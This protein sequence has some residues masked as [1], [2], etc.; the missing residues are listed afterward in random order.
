LA[1]SINAAFHLSDTVKNDAL[2][3][4][5]E[6]EIVYLSMTEGHLTNEE[7]SQIRPHYEEKRPI[8]SYLNSIVSL[9]YQ[10]VT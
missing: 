8:K 6:H 7:D 1:L 3:F 5:V 4:P 10:R 2:M 9:I